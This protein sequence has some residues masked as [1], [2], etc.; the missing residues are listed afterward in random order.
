MPRGDLLGSLE[1]IVLLAL[2]RLG[3][4]AY[5]MTVRRQIEARTGRN[6]S[7]GAVYSTLERLEAKGYVTSSTG[8][9]TAARGGRAKRIFQIDA[10]GERA[11]RTSQE[12][13]RKM[14]HGLK[15]RWGTV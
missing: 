6:I 14:T 1:Y 11:L 7:I 9:P 13:I 3:P 4:G 2:V 5:G 10:A 8:A 15:R 12:A